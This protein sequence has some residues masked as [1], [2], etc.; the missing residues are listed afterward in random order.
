MNRI[1]GKLTLGTPLRLTGVGSL[2]LDNG[3]IYTTLTNLLALDRTSTVFGSGLNAVTQLYES[4]GSDLSHVDGPMAKE[5]NSTARFTFPVGDAGHLGEI[6]ITPNNTNITTFRSQYFHY[7][8]VLGPGVAVASPLHHPSRLEYWQLDRTAG[9]AN[10]RVTLHWTDYSVVS[11]S[12]TERRELRVAR[13]NGTQ[14]ENRGP[15]TGIGTNPTIPTG[16][17]PGKGMVT[18]DLV[19]NFSPFTLATTIPNNPLPIQ[20]VDVKATVIEKTVKI[21]WVTMNEENSDYFE[22]QRSY[23]GKAF[24]TIGKVAAAGTS[25]TAL[26]YSF[27]DANP[28]T[29]NY[30]RLKMVDKDQ[31]D[32]Y[33]K[34]VTA[35]LSSGQSSSMIAVEVFPNPFDGK[36]LYLKADYVG[37]LTVTFINILGKEVYRET[38]TTGSELTTIT[39]KIELLPGA[40]VMTIQA[41]NQTT[42][43]KVV[44]K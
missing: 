42:K 22:V 30:Y 16:T 23:D 26:S 41:G 43:H 35:Q 20:L 28:V 27:I 29:M 4:G 8:P 6:G 14:W 44:V 1:S 19:T 24:I 13:H 3:I 25:T 12:A 36:T 31:K 39:P 10:G 9:T 15:G 21:S 33:S 17:N 37:K 7:D 38:L 11:L 40:Y 18:S 5:T 2:R 34:T 32:S